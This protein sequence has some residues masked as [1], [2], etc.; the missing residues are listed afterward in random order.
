MSTAQYAHI[1][2]GSDQVPMLAGT[3]TKVVEVVLDHLAHGVDAHEIHRQYPHLSLGQIH[4]ALA[5]YY[6]HQEEMDRDIERRLRKV[7]D[8]RPSVG[9]AA[10][11]DKLRAM[12]RLP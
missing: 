7:D 2:F 9:D 12:G 1:T 10:V 6:D 5:Y 11:R 8:L 4:S 3:R